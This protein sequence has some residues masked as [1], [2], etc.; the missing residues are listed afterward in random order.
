MRHK[1]ETWWGVSFV[2]PYLGT[3]CETLYH[4]QIGGRKK[5]ILTNNRKERSYKMTL[6]MDKAQTIKG[7]N[8][9]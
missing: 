3:I 1:R 8:Y 6:V 7:D 4:H 9:N 2:L 5:T